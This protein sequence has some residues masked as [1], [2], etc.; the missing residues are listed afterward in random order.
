MLDVN[1]IEALK[2]S[3]TTGRRFELRLVESIV[4]LFS[5]QSHDEICWKLT[6]KQI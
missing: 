6:N 2:S 3:K 4:L 1:I 5:E